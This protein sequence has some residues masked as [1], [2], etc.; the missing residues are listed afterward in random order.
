MCAASPQSHAKALLLSSLSLIA[1]TSS[2]PLKIKDY[3]CE[4]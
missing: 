4:K 3:L 2:M 1:L